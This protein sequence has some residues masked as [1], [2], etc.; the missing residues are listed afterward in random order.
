[1]ESDEDVVPGFEEIIARFKGPEEMAN[2]SGVE[3]AVCRLQRA[4]RA[5]L[6]AN[7]EES[8]SKRR[9]TLVNEYFL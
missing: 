2:K 3:D 4:K 1:M 5:L 7:A 9:Q 8:R 6:S